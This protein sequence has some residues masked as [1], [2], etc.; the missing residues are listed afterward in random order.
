[1]LIEYIQMTFKI[2]KFALSHQG[3]MN[4]L[5]LNQLYCFI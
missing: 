1:M 3:Q 4:G 5:L 2:M